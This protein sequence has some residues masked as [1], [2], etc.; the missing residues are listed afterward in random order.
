M[1]PYRF[2]ITA[3][4][5]VL[6]ILPCAGL[7]EKCLADVEA[8]AVVVRVQQPRGHV[9]AALMVHF[10]AHWIEHIQAKQLDLVLRLRLFVVGNFGHGG[11]L[12]RPLD[13]GDFD[14]RQTAHTENLARPHVFE[15]VT[16]HQV[17]RRLHVSRRHAHHLIAFLDEVA[18]VGLDGKANDIQVRVL[19]GVGFAGCFIDQ[20]L[21][22]RSVLRAKDNRHGP[23]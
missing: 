23:M 6:Q 19:F 16:H 1:I 18:R 12:Q 8:Q 11:R 4:Q 5:C 17:W 15:Q 7:R 20:L 22:H 2:L 13:F 9:V 21:A 14:F 10:H 3:F